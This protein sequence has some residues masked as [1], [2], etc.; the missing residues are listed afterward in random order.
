MVLRVT[1]GDLIRA[2][3]PFQIACPGLNGAACALQ[4]IRYL[5]M[6]QFSVCQLHV[7]SGVKL[8]VPTRYTRVFDGAPLLAVV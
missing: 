1:F 7:G 8:A 4:P 2:E 3:D 6:S 5:L